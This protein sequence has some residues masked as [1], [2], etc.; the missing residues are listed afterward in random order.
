MSEDLKQILG[1]IRNSLNSIDERLGLLLTAT[2]CKLRGTFK[3]GELIKLIE[4]QESFSHSL[5]DENDRI[6]F[7]SKEEK[8]YDEN[9]TRKFELLWGYPPEYVED[10][11]SEKFVKLDTSRLKFNDLI[12]KLMAWGL[13][14]N[15]SRAYD[16]L[17]DELAQ[18]RFN[19]GA[20]L[21]F[22]DKENKPSSIEIDESAAHTLINTV[23]RMIEGMI[24]TPPPMM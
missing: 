18:Q 9:F 8:K 12:K 4:K 21:E 6:A 17:R 7:E 14:T 20:I 13:A 3:I 16:K 24:I 5:S 19:K 23:D 1:D 15:Q 2:D 11:G 22:L 10:W